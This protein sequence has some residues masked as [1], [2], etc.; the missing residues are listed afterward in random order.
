MAKKASDFDTDIARFTPRQL[1]VCKAIDEAQAKY[2]LYGGAVGGGK[3]YL[4]RWVA[5][6]ILMQAYADH[7]IKNGQVMLACEDYPSLKDRQIG[8][9]TT[10]FPAWLGKYHD[11]HRAHGKCFILAPQYGS[12][13]I[14]LRNLDD[15]S[16]YQSAEFI[17]ILVDELTKNPLQTFTDLR[18]RIR[19]PGMPDNECIFIG[20]TNPG[21]I[22]HNY[23][24][25]YWID[26]TYP[27]EFIEPID[28]R[29]LFKFIPSKAE[30]NPHLDASYWSVL[31]TLP[32]NLRQ[33]FRDGSWDVYQG[34]AFTF[35]REVHMLKEAI[36]IPQYAPLYFTMD[37][38]FGAPFSIGWWWVD[39]DGRGYRFSEWYGWN[40]TPNQGLRMED[41]RIAR[42][43]KLKESA[44]S[45]KYNI[46]FDHII[47]LAGPDCFQ[48][49]A[50]YQG[51]GQGPSTAEVF[52][53]EGIYLAPGDPS[54]ALKIRQF[55]ERLKIPED[56]TMPMMMIY[57]ECTQFA[58]TI[59]DIPVDKNNPEEVDTKSEDH[60]FD[61]S[62]HFAMARPIALQTPK[63]SL[64]QAQKHIE[65][66]Q[67]KGK[68][69]YEEALIQEQMIQEEFLY[70]EHRR[71][72]GRI[73]GDVD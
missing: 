66:Q 11:D 39:A 63:P 43:I 21:G 28:Y 24:K 71:M 57:P 50:N 67:N 70:R 8:R 58:R 34:Q 3:S 15:P 55:R 22:G 47:R 2:I 44:L 19:W 26:R 10:D 32:E 40:G 9:I 20:A 6:R 73:Y 72:E 7:Q 23:C 62:C 1:E 5:V 65:T 52:A 53:G 56:G 16:K 61:E 18:M 49:K 17:A 38:G 4:L 29:P 27:P 14:C 33:A 51:G 41:S 64:T 36:Q 12:G 60:V 25:A 59:P 45:E 42:E 31:N 68:G 35:S 30:D 46:S 13:I 48:K 54:R 37:W 69:G